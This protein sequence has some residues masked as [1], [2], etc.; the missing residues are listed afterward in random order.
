MNSSKVFLALFCSTILCLNVQSVFAAVDGAAPNALVKKEK[1]PVDLQADKLSHDSKNKILKASGSVIL[2]QDGRTLRADEVTYDLKNDRVV[3]RGHVELLEA[4]GDIHHADMVELQDKMKNGFVEHLR[5]QMSDG[6]YFSA[7]EGDRYD[8]TRTVMRSATYTP[9]DVC[10]ETPDKA[11]V[12]QIRAAEVEHDT[13]NQSISYKHARFEFAGVPLLYTPYFSHPDGSVERKSG[14][15]A[16]SVGFNS[17]L[18]M[19]LENSYYLDVA[20]DKDLTFSLLAMSQENPLVGTEYRQR[21]NNAA[22]KL[23]GGLTHSK[24]VEKRDGLDQT[25]GGQ[26][27]GHFFVEGEWDIN[28]KWRAKTDISWASD[29]QYMRQ[30]N[31]SSDSVLRSELELEHFSGRDYGVARLLTFQD[32][33]VGTVQADQPEVLPEI[34]INMQGEPGSMPVL[35]GSWVLGGSFL[36][37][38]RE[39]SGQDMGRLSVNAGWKRRVVSDMGLVL[40]AQAMM[41]GDIYRVSDRDVANTTAGRSRDTVGTQVFPYLNVKAGYPM[42]KHYNTLQAL[43]SPEVSITVAPNVDVSDDIPNEDSSDVQIDATNLFEPNRFP[44]LDRVE[45]RSHVT[46]GLRSGIYGHSGAYANFFL[47]QSYRLN[48][49]DNPFPVGSGLETQTSDVVG[50]LSSGL[51]GLYDMNYRFQLSSDDFSAERHEVDAQIYTERFSLGSRY[52]FAKALGGT[53]ITEEREQIQ[54]NASYYLNVDWRIG[55]GGTYD[56]GENNGWRQNFLQLDYLGQCLFWSLTGQRNYTED[57]T[58]ESDTEVLFRIGLK[59][60]GDFENSALRNRSENE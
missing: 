21:W 15:L 43:I 20:P 18:G 23:S 44:G 39:G 49:D 24:R 42:V 16:P 19:F 26:L 29:D 34:V 1:T 40:N 31:Q 11:P 59:N 12:W 32:T 9:C 17:S 3:A 58:G 33:R 53:D 27:R 10:E 60:L 52:L 37:L 7:R 6:A 5:S 13:E 36:G 50:E 4:N 35:G 48:D 56:L 47:G 8:G 2:Q 30:Y 14:F 38:R 28:E 54:A 51:N 57:A 41:R 25:V 22:L 45:D 55:T 46:Y